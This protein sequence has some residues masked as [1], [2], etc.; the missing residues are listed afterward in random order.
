[1]QHQPNWRIPVGML[2]LLAAL[3]AYGLMLA[4]YLPGLIGHWHVLAQAPVYLVLGVIWI[5]PLRR[6][7]AW[8]EAG[9]RR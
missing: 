1:M 3:A 4:R 8:M 2:G 9:R 5:M 6:F 7:L